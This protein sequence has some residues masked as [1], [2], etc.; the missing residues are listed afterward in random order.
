MGSIMAH[1][2]RIEMARKVQFRPSRST[3]AV[4][5]WAS[6]PQYVFAWAEGYVLDQRLGIG[7]SVYAAKGPEYFEILLASASPEGE[8]RDRGSA[9]D[10]RARSS[11]GFPS[12]IPRSFSNGRP[13]R[14]PGRESVPAKP[15]G[16]SSHAPHV[17]GCFRKVLRSPGAEIHGFH[18]VAPQSLF[19][20]L[21]RAPRPPVLRGASSRP[22]SS[23]PSYG[24]GRRSSGFPA[25]RR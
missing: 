2:F 24:R 14:R 20:Q 5:A 21:P 25:P 12:T 3:G 8:A 15:P 23:R 4:R 18:A 22:D 6:T 16:R 19:A 10:A 11:C 9:A 13:G 17:R 1:A 7:E